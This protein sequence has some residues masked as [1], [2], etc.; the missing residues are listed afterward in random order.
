MPVSRPDP[1]DVTDEAIRKLFAAHRQAEHHREHGGPQRDLHAVLG[2]EPPEDKAGSGDYA[3]DYVNFMISGP[4]NEALEVLLRVCDAA[5]DGA[6]LCWIGTLLVE[7]LLDLHWSDI[8]EGFERES[9][10]SAPLRAAYSC[11]SLQLPRRATEWKRR[12]QH[13][14]APSGEPG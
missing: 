11:A 5:P 14:V 13:L 3:L 9:R 2:I 4:P 12:M 1:P 7:P 10:K 8:G 6:S